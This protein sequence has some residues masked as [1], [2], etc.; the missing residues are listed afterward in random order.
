MIN[1]TL[2]ILPIGNQYPRSNK[3]K[4]NYRNR[5][6]KHKKLER[7]WFGILILSFLISKIA[8]NSSTALRIEEA[9][10]AIF[11]AIVSTNFADSTEVVNSINS[12]LKQYVSYIGTTSKDYVSTGTLINTIL[13]ASYLIIIAF[14]EKRLHGLFPY[15]LETYSYYAKVASGLRYGSIILIFLSN[16][17]SVTGHHVCAIICCSINYG[18]AFNML[19]FQQA[20][21]NRSNF[22]EHAHSHYSG[23]RDEFPHQ[24]IDEMLYIFHD[25][26]MKAGK[27]NIA[28]KHEYEFIH[29]ELYEAAMICVSNQGK[30]EDRQ[31]WLV[32]LRRYIEMC[33][34]GAGYTLIL[35]LSHYL[36]Q[37]DKDIYAVTWFDL[38]LLEL[39]KG[40]ENHEFRAA[41]LTT[42]FLYSPMYTN[43][44]QEFL[45][46]L[47]QY[48]DEEINM[49]T[50]FS[51]TLNCFRK[52]N[53]K[54]TEELPELIRIT[55]LIK[56]VFN[57]T[58]D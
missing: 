37:K 8:L 26:E 18:I 29:R 53:S 36:H 9:G 15:E 4:G 39:I 50:T 12:V 58:G 43:E 16:L 44:N 19:W 5:Q 34:N 11:Q 42:Y 6:K 31:T 52:G 35:R 40:S 10:D 32:V 7:L 45:E 14:Q 51:K 38:T 25:I 20:T 3:T 24:W 49:I 47:K 27:G 22:T 57:Q 41:F 23:L 48:I 17:L 46:H 56:A 21:Y 54:Q 13:Q 33:L 28:E 1:R 2:D 55:K 30:D